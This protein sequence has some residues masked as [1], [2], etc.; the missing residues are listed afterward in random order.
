MALIS[1][2]TL[3]PFS[4]VLLSKMTLSKKLL[5]DTPGINTADS[6]GNP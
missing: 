5:S 3:N 1:Q 6:L 4:V 2:P